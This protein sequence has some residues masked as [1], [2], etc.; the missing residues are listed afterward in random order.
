MQLQIA[1]DCECATPGE[2]GVIGDA[3]SSHTDRWWKGDNIFFQFHSNLVCLIDDAPA[4]WSLQCG[5]H[6]INSWNSIV[7]SA[8]IPE[9]QTQFLF[10]PIQIVWE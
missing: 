8:T 4:R 6:L 5:T 10:G 7:P 3:A 2:N 9:T 1:F